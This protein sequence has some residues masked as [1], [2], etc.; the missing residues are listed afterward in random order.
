MKKVLAAALIAGS[1]ISTAFAADLPSRKAAVY[2]PPPPVFTWTGFY[3]GLNAG[4]TVSN[5]NNITTTGFAV[6]NPFAA[7]PGFGPFQNAI[8]TND[9]N[10][11]GTGSKAGALLG[12]QAGYNWQFG[13]PFLLGVET[14]I[15]GVVSSGSTRGFASSFPVIGF[16]PFTDNARGVVSKRLDYLGTVRGRVGYLVT[17]TFLIYATGGLAYGGVKSSTAIIHNVAP[18]NG[19]ITV[20]GQGGFSS[21]KVGYTV[22]GGVEW[23]FMPSWSLK[24][25]Y[26]YYDLRTVNYNAGGTISSAAGAFTNSEAVRTRVRFDGH[27]GRLGVNYHFW[28]PAAPVV[29]RY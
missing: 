7:V 20:G 12:G 13:T 11:I 10:F 26:L 2:A 18:A 21:A 9:T 17:P 14:D 5:N 4:G 27:V 19:V 1:T 23:M 8:V 24:A 25:E 29:A 3:V 22:G 15:Q 28:G 6:A 16:P